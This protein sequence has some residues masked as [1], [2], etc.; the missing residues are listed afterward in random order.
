MA[1]TIRDDRLVD[2]PSSSHS[3]SPPHTYFLSR[4]QHLMNL[5]AIGHS[6]NDS[7]DTTLDGR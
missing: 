2:S 5:D 3:S 6:F 4:T 7:Y 1:V